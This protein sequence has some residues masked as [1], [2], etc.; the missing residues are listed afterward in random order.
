MEQVIIIRNGNRVPIANRR[1]ATGIKSAKQNWSLSGE[2][3]VDI[4]VVSPFPQ[5]YEIGDKIE[6]FGRIYKLNRLPK[7]KKTGMHE[8]EYDLELSL[9]HI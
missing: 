3:T 9:I 7:A 8:F 4:T 2:E 5:T 1:T 6:V